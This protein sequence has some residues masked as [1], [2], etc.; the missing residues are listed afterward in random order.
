MERCELSILEGLPQSEDELDEDQDSLESRLVI[1]LH[2]KLGVYHF[3][4]SPTA[5]HISLRY[6]EDA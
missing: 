3:P 1:K 2:C 4:Y 6:R 5:L